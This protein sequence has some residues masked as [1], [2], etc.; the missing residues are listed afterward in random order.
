M[1]HIRKILIPSLNNRKLPRLPAKRGD[2]RLYRGKDISRLSEFVHIS[3]IREFVPLF[4]HRS[5]GFDQEIPSSIDTV[6][7]I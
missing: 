6:K 1:H 4:F 2:L 3:R 5:N 7:S